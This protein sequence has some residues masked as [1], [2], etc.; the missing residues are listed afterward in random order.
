MPDQTGVRLALGFAYI[1]RNDHGFLLLALLDMFSPLAF[2]TGMILYDLSFSVPPISHLDFFPFEMF[3]E[4]LVVIAI[5]D[6]A[7]L[8]QHPG[9]TPG[10]AEPDK[11][12]GNV[13]VP[14]PDG[15]V[16][17]LGELDLTRENNSRALVHQLLVFDYE[18]LDSLV[19][20][21]DNVSW[22]PRPQASRATTMKT[23]LC[24][25]TSLL[26]SE[27]D[28]FAKT[29]QAL[30]SIESPKALAWGPH[31]GPEL[32][33]RP[34]DKLLHRMTMP[35]QFP[36]SPNG[37]SETSLSSEKSTSASRDYDTPTTF[38]EITRSMQLANRSSTNRAESVSS[39]KEHS[40]DRTSTNNMTASD[41]VKNRIKGRRGVVIGSLYLKV[42]RWP[43]ALKELVEAAATARAGSDY[44]WHA[45]ALELVLL[46]LLMF[47]WAGMDF[48]VS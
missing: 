32:R 29:L 38:D 5:A 43:D 17:L 4:P 31:R 15:L 11:E 16:E 44:V 24:D 21:P 22:I 8:S 25:I 20:G 2:P 28:E 33:P 18:G 19:S 36:S 9:E 45:K 46:C 12:R 37:A 34:V 27:L 26:L 1:R 41:R 42:G 23:V 35:A 7:E 13:K 40:R 3:R 48:Q 14:T 39:S 47:G 6:G 10:R 30:P